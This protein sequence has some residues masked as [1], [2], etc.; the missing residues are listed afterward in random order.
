MTKEEKVVLLTNP[1]RVLEQL[2]KN[3]I[4]DSEQNRR[5]QLDQGVYWEEPL[6]G[7]ASGLDPLFF[8]YKNHHRLLPSHAAR[9][10]RSCFERERKR[11]PP[12]R[13]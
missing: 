10:H 6:V 1:N 13:D 4:K 12:Y 3:F 9:N 5:T 7:F 11:P 8:E 2:I